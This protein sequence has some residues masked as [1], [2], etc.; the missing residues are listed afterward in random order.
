M[1]RNDWVRYDESRSYR[2]VIPEEQRRDILVLPDGT[3]EFRPCHYSISYRYYESPSLPESPCWQFSSIGFNDQTTGRLVHHLNELARFWPELAVEVIRHVV[4]F[5]T[6]RNGSVD[7]WILALAE[8]LNGPL[9]DQEITMSDL[10]RITITVTAKLPTE[11]TDDQ[12]GIAD[13]ARE[14]ITTQ[15]A[16][17]GLTEVDL[18]VTG[19]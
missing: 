2:Y 13:S 11:M 16:E 9:D 6:E 7:R 18:Q 10:R 19:S 15:L 3:R 17:M 4:W 12:H 1:P 14:R 8:R 5:L